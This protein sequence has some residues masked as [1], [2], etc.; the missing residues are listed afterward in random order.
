[1]LAP[2][3][4]S[5]LALALLAAAVPGARLAAQ[6]ATQARRSGD[7]R[8]AGTVRAQAGRPARRRVV[9]FRRGPRGAGAVAPSTQTDAE[10]RFR[11]EVPAGVAGDLVVRRAGSSESGAPAGALAAGAPTRRRASRS[12]R[13]PS[14][15]W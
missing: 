4:R 11:L 3:R 8:G 2:R 6:P 13:S 7:G 14:S 12:R 10:G 1:M 15:T 5:A 9:G